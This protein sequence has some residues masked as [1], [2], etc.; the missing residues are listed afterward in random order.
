MCIYTYIQIYRTHLICLPSLLLADIFTLR[1]PLYRERQLLTNIVTDEDLYA[2]VD[3]IGLSFLLGLGSL[4]EHD[5]TAYDWDGDD[6]ET[7]KDKNKDKE[8]RDNHFG[9][10]RLGCFDFSSFTSNSKKDYKMEAQML[11]IQAALERS[12]EDLERERDH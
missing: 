5:H 11:E 9:E 1:G 7:E 6:E 12:N 4:D 3:C 10:S 8:N 2:T